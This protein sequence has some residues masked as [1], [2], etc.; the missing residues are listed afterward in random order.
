VEDLL[1][2]VK[3]QLYENYSS[4]IVRLPYNEGGLIAL[5]HDQGKVD[6]VEQEHGGTLIQ[7]RIPGRLL[8]RFQQYM[9]E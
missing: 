5:F 9:T 4:I 6:R 3:E 8:A 7:G 1:Q 2:M